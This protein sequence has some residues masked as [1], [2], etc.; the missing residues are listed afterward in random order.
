MLPKEEH[1]SDE[2]LVQ[3]AKGN[4]LKAFD[5]LV[6]RHQERIFNLVLR[7][8]GEYHRA[9]DLSQIVFLKAFQG[10]QSFKGESAFFTWL[11]RIALNVC[12]TERRRIQAEKKRRLISLEGGKRIDEENSSRDI[13][14]LSE[15]PLGRLLSSE[16]ERAV[17]KAIQG[18]DEEFKV[19][20]ALRDLEGYSYEEISG[21][22]GWPLGTV[23]SRLHRARLI[24][25]D[26]LK[27]YLAE[28]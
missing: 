2:S 14:D 23:R 8:T 24:L 11:F 25:R 5:E 15:E 27:D 3:K 13:P 4:D 18:L 28:K 6:L 1:I 19:V 21:L 26:Q 17:F 7:M 9:N 16:T 12:S 10:I 20:V 22:T